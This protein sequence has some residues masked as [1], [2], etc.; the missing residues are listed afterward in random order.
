M[1]GKQGDDW[2]DNLGGQVLKYLD[3]I[4]YIS[5]LIDTVRENERSK[6]LEKISSGLEKLPPELQDQREFL[7]NIIA[8][9]TNCLIDNQSKHLSNIQDELGSIQKLLIN[10]N[11][12]NIAGQLS[13]IFAEADA[14]AQIRRLADQAE[15]IA[16]S[17][18]GIEQNLNAIHM[19]G[20]KFPQPV[21]SYVRMMIDKHSTEEVPHYFAVFHRGTQ[22]HATFHELDQANPLGPNYLGHKADLD[23]LCAFLVE[24]VRPRIG[25]DPVLHILMPSAKPVAI[26]EAVKFPEVMR[27]FFIDGERGDEGS[28]FVW[29][30]TP[31]PY[32]QQHL[33]HIGILKQRDIYVLQAGAGVP[34]LSWWFD[35]LG[36][37]LEPKFFIDPYYRLPTNVGLIVAGGD[38][39]F[40]GLEP[41]RTLSQPSRRPW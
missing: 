21:R 4:P 30:C 23:E 20:K 35:S 8:W 29:L 17:L 31:E 19:Q 25:S 15:K 22:W 5:Q 3:Y 24:E 2:M 14:I 10:F 18:T 40:Y 16:G 1:D 9:S 41:P 6:Q 28:P 33:R 38:Y 32:D 13:G 12:V 11:R 39:A 37:T 7:R 34:I 26:V 27:P 36:Y